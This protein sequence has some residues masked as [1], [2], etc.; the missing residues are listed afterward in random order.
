MSNNHFYSPWVKQILSSQSQIK[1]VSN[2]HING[3]IIFAANTNSEQSMTNSAVNQR[4]YQTNSEKNIKNQNDNLEKQDI[5]TPDTTDKKYFQATE[6]PENNPNNEETSSSDHNTFNPFEPISSIAAHFLGFQ[7]FSDNGASENSLTHFF[8]NNKQGNEFH[9]LNL[10]VLHGEIG[11]TTPG[12]VLV[13]LS[14]IENIFHNTIIFNTQQY[15]SIGN[16][17]TPALFVNF[18]PVAKYDFF[19]FSNFDNAFIKPA[20]SLPNV[21]ANDIDING[22]Q[23]RAI[24]KST[25]VDNTGA[26]GAYDFLVNPF[27]G[28]V[29]YQNTDIPFSPIQSGNVHFLYSTQDASSTSQPTYAFIM[30]IDFFGFLHEGINGTYGAENIFL[31][32]SITINSLADIN[33]NIN[34]VSPFNDDAIFAA[35]GSNNIAGDVLNFSQII[36]IDTA[37]LF[38]PQSPARAELIS[39]SGDDLIVGHNFD[40]TLFG[41]GNN[42]NFTFNLDDSI[43]GIGID[44]A[45]KHTAGNDVVYG[46]LG[47]DI[48]FG[49]WA[50]INLILNTFTSTAPISANVEIRFGQDILIGG[51]GFDLLYGDLNPVALNPNSLPPDLTLIRASDIFIFEPGMN[52]DIIGDFESN[53]DFIDLKQFNI[54]GNTNQE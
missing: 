53:R 21:L 49:D 28:E 36:N 2:N 6:N 16:I 22:D 23:L 48:L 3:K 27:T 24:L 4:N 10:N 31:T 12:N 9:Q 42:L 37:L 1:L 34:N 5:N 35:S 41:D 51:P 40:D 19:V 17:Y 29:F 52:A 13:S 43:N 14:F 15:F 50:N 54:P 30:N 26:T 11:L 20:G 32:E 45:I 39:Q 47:T 25:I 7:H 46:N 8:K 38:G 33:P 18:P 44:S